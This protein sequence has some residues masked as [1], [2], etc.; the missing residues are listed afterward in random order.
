MNDTPETDA[1]AVKN[2]Y[3]VMS[4]VDVDFARKL[5][6]D[7][8]IERKI[9]QKACLEIARLERERDE[10]REQ[11]AMLRNVAELLLVGELKSDD[12]RKIRIELD[13]LMEGAK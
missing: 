3:G 9:A 6:R 13:Q 5:E 2:I 12:F 10:A 8:N 11:N 4:E 1:V 7:L